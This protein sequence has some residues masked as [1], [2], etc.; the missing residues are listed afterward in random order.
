MSEHWIGISGTH[1]I[2]TF[3]Y[4]RPKGNATQTRGLHNAGGRLQHEA[5]PCPEGVGSQ[6]VAAPPHNPPPPEAADARIA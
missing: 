5:V 2:L 6:G 4:H 3:I 1:L